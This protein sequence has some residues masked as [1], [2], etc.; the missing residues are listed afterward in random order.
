MKTMMKKMEIIIEIEKD[1]NKIVAP[2]I[3]KYSEIK[4]IDY[5]K[6]SIWANGKMVI[7][8]KSTA[9]I[10]DYSK[11]E[12]HTDLMRSIVGGAA[13]LQSMYTFSVYWTDKQLNKTSDEIFNYIK[14]KV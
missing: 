13:K 3:I 7:V 8:P 6:P 2:I 5:G 10:M 1:A 14:G 4:E 12:V 9:K 11:D